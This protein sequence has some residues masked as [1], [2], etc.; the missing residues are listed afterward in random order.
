MGKPSINPKFK[1]EWARL[2][3]IHD[4]SCAHNNE[5]FP[6]WHRRYLLEVENALIEA[7]KDLGGDGNIR[8]PYWKW[9]SDPTN[10]FPYEVYEKFSNIESIPGFPKRHLGRG[11][12]RELVADI[13]SHLEQVDTANKAF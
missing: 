13:L 12:P 11:A 2:A 8:I 6:V 9:D 5:Q 3:K 7:D 1:N 10:N 4:T